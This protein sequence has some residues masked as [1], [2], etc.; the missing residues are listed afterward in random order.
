MLAATASS[1]WGPGYGADAA[2]DRI[3]QENGNYWQTVAKTDCGAWWQADLGQ[4]VPVRGVKIA[5]ARFEDKYHA[6]P[7]RVI[8]Q[9]SDA[10]GDGP[11][12][13][14]LTI[15]PD[16]IPAD[17]APFDAARSWDYAF[18]EPASGRFVRL[19]F[20]DGDRITLADGVASGQYQSPVHDWGVPARLREL[21]VA[22][23]LH[24][25]QA[26]VSV[27]TS[28]DGFMT[29]TSSSTLPVPDGVKSWAL[30]DSQRHAVRVRFELLRPAG[31]T[32]SPVI[33]GFRITADPLPAGGGQ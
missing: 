14:V 25:A 32:A 6:P 24:G 16:K 22:A 17:E 8:V 5:W 2:A 15:E 28:D 1:E 18:S 11:W 10:G 13:D 12:R 31:A 19:F 23:D 27:E 21:T 3:A 9:F 7:A 33:D 4:I 29:T 30:K 20:P 26:F